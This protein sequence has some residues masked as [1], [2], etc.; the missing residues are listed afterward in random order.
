MKQVLRRIAIQGAVTAL[1]LGI[2]GFMLAELASIWLAGSPGTRTATGE[3]MDSTDV[4]GAIS[5]N[6]RQRL[7]LTMAILGFAF[8]AI[9][10]LVLHLWR[11]RKPVPPP[12]P[13]APQPDPAEKLLEE[14]LAK[15]EAENRQKAED[16]EQKTENREQKAA[17][18]KQ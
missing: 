8:V 12:E 13:T 17:E 6:L 4:N 16:R 3:A 1:I 10:E 14:I 2:V 15:V 5:S 7:P 11:S 18:S 9:G